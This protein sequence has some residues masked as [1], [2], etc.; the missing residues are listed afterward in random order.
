MDK[1]CDACEFLQN[2][3]LKTRILLTDNWT[4]GV[5]TN[6]AYFGRA[7]MTLRNHKSSLGSL[8][9]AE[10]EDFEHTVARIEKA[11]KEVYGAEPLNWGCFMNHAFRAKPFNPHVHWHIYPRYE[12]APVLDGVTYDDSLF[13]HFYNNKAE[14][15]VSDETAEKIASK[16]A[17]YLKEN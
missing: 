9:K 6:Q 10:W 11:Y 12:V 16:L 15:L 14:R 8:T 17:D 5:G 1:K 13:G 4:V 3:N 7:Y 2:P